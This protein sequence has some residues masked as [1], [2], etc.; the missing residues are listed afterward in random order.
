MSSDK[1]PTLTD[2]LSNAAD[3]FND[4]WENTA[5][6]DEFEPLPGGTYR[7]LVTDGK[8]SESR[9]NKT[10]SYR[11]AFQVLEGSFKGRK[12]WEDYWLTPAAL[13]TSKREL[14]RLGIERPEQL[15]QPPPAGLIADVRVA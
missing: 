13:P 14:R 5:A 8:L 9:T 11:V 15:K 4:V 6:A 2:I 7:S 3:G 1:R 10:P 12:L